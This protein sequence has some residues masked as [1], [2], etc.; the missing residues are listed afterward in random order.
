MS[1]MMYRAGGAIT[2]SIAVSVYQ[3]GV[4]DT[5]QWRELV[6]TDA[7]VDLRVVEDFD[8]GL[9]LFPSDRVHLEVASNKELTRHRVFRYT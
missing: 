9:L 1:G 3:N 8:E 5:T 6:R 2:T 4:A 7:R